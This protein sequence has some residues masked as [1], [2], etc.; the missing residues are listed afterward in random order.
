[1]YQENLFTIGGY[2]SLHKT[3]NPEAIVLCSHNSPEHFGSMSS[4][5][6]FISLLLLKVHQFNAASLGMLDLWGPP[7]N[8]IASGL[9]LLSRPALEVN[10]FG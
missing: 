10:P 5:S 7:V 9:V 8:I 2:Q 4:M 3:V 6:T 1:M